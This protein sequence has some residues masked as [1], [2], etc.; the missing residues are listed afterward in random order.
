MSELRSSE[1]AIKIVFKG[2]FC[3]SF[4]VLKILNLGRQKSFEVCYF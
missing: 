3:L 2:N 1:N 4:G